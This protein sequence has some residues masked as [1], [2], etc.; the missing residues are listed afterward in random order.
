MFNCF[1]GLT[2]TILVVFYTLIQISL[3]ANK[4]LKRSANKGSNCLK[5]IY[6]GR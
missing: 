4:V 6:I 5:F 1:N 2:L 3:N